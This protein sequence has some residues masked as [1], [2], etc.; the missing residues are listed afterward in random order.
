M[1]QSPQPQIAFPPA[2]LPKNSLPTVST[3]EIA[4][5]QF[6]PVKI[7]QNSLPTITPERYSHFLRQKKK[8][9]V[10]S[11]VISYNGTCGIDQRK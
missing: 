2:R 1:H 6:R 3:P 4:K 7:H 11:A 8:Y 10:G 9:F 5:P